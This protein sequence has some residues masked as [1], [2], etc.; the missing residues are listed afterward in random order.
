MAF[1]KRNLFIFFVALMLSACTAPK[2]YKVISGAVHNTGSDSMF[3]V[4]AT[5]LYTEDQAMLIDTQFTNKEAQQIVE[6]IKKSGKPLTLIYISHGDPDFYFGLD[7]VLNAYPNAHVIATS[8]TVE[9]IRREGIG[10]LKYWRK[11]IG[12][13]APKRIVI[14]TA[15]TSNTF[16]FG[17]DSFIVKGDDPNRT[18][19]WMPKQRMIIGGSLLSNNMFIWTADARTSEQRMLWDKTVLEMRNLSPRITI[20]G[21]YLGNDPVANESIEFTHQYINTYD[22]VLKSNHSIYDIVRKMKEHYPQLGGDL[23][24]EVSTTIILNNANF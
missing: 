12:D 24:L 17:Q 19:L 16:D 18:Y 4:T 11:Y 21:H 6:E 13:Q 8:A 10:K 14:P 7:T 5:I 22:E 1:L 9:K 20:P 15:L 3:P 23:N 2:N